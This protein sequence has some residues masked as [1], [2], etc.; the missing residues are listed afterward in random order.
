MKKEENEGGRGGG[1]LFPNPQFPFMSDN[2]MYQ[3]PLLKT[4]PSWIVGGLFIFVY[5][6]RTLVILSL[7]QIKKN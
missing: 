5:V 4:N 1:E 6:P 2:H 7:L 3:A